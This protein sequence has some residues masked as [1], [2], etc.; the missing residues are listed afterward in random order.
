MPRVVMD[1]AY[2]L[3]VT[4][5]GHSQSIWQEASAR[6][7]TESFA[8]LACSGAT[9]IDMTSNAVDNPPT[10]DDQAGSTV[11]GRAGGNHDEAL[12]LEQGYLDSTT[13]LVTVSVG[14]DARFAA[15]LQ[16]CVATLVDCTNPG[17]RL[18]V[19]GHLDPQPLIQYEPYV[20]NTL[21]PSHL[22]AVY[23][24]IH[25]LAPDA[26]IVVFGY[27]HIFPP[28]PLSLC[29]GVG[30][31]DQIWMD[32]MADDMDKSLQSVVSTE[33]LSG[34]NFGFVDPRSAFDGTNGHWACG[35]APWLNALVATDITSS[36]HPTAAGQ[37]AYAQ[38]V[39]GYLAGH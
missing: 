8:F 19:H 15:V 7:T 25:G 4:L 37:A 24:T 3:A 23:D 32:Q 30:I 22:R 38:L 2:R 36:F 27:P 17:Y 11:L 26:K 14:D 20:I 28:V 34:M 39:N 29:G 1:N 13:T 5:P 35:A 16:G 18:T 9:S 10:P 12:E 21:L 33:A 6:G 31:Q